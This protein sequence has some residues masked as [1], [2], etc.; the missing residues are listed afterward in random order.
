MSAT[1]REMWSF[2]LIGLAY[3]VFASAV[4]LFPERTFAMRLSDLMDMAWF[5]GSMWLLV[6][7]RNY[8]TRRSVPSTERGA[9]RE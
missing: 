8:F 7:I 3:S 2:W 4:G 5:I 1:F 6:C 9:A